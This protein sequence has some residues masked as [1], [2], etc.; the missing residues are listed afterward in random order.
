MHQ[1]DHLLTVH[2]TSSNLT[3][4]LLRT[5]RVSSPYLLYLSVAPT[6]PTPDYPGFWAVRVGL[7][8]TWGGHSLAAKMATGAH[9]LLRL[10]SSVVA[11]FVKDIVTL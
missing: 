4:Y 6:H 11:S 8:K 10:H 1:T 5:T 9:P 3:N 2:R 7:E